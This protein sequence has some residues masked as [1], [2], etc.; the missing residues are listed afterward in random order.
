MV[1]GTGL[2]V[3]SV[4][5]D[6]EPNIVSALQVEESLPS[7]QKP[8]AL[9]PEQNVHAVSTLFINRSKGCLNHFLF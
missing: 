5:R 7:A 3:L 4:R 2:Q 8:W 9:Q 1:A 6:S